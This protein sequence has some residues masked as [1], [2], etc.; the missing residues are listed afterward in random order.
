MLKTKAQ[1]TQK[2]GASERSIEGG[3]GPDLCE[4]T[5]EERD[6]EQP[7]LSAD[8]QERRVRLREAKAAAKRAGEKV[9]AAE[10]AFQQAAAHGSATGEAAELTQARLA[11]DTANQVVAI[12]QAALVPAIGPELD[13]VR[14]VFKKRQDE[15]TS[16]WKRAEVTFFETVKEAYQ[17]FLEVHAT[18]S[19]SKSYDLQEFQRLL[20]GVRNPKVREAYDEMV[21]ENAPARPSFPDLE[22]YAQR[23][24]VSFPHRYITERNI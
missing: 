21:E 22:I 2:G 11:A 24:G 20:G 19:Q 4:A 7:A 14:P 13:A 17:Q 3:Q 12:Q 18:L 1:D 16:T 23:V 10:R 8:F 15:R 9:E 5:A 6:K